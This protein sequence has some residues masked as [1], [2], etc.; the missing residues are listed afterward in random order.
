MI[1]LSVEGMLDFQPKARSLVPVSQVMSA[2][3][4][5]LKEMEGYT[6]VNTN[7]KAKH[8]KLLIWRKFQW[9]G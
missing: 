7:D 4:K 2:K 8:P 6:P 3:E 1:K 5:F 9:S